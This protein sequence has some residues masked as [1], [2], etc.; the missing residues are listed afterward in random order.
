M[1]G[2]QQSHSSPVQGSPPPPPNTAESQRSRLLEN[3][4]VVV[5][6]R[7]SHRAPSIQS[8]SSSSPAETSAEN[9]NTTSEH[10]SAESSESES[11]DED[12]IQVE[13]SFNRETSLKIVHEARRPSTSSPVRP[14]EQ[15]LTDQ[16]LDESAI[17]VQPPV[18]KPA[19]IP[20]PTAAMA[21]TNRTII[22][23]PHDV[24]PHPSDFAGTAAEDPESWLNFLQRYCKCKRMTDEMFTENFGLY[25]K[26]MALQWYESLSDTD[27]T[28][29]ARLID[30]FKRRFYLSN[31]EKLRVMSDLF[32]RQQ[33]PEESVDEYF[34]QMQ[35]SARILG[36]VPDEQLKNAI[37]LG[38]KPELKKH[39]M[40]V[41]PT[42]LQDL[43]RAAKVAESAERAAGPSSIDISE[44][45]KR[46]ELTLMEGAARP[47]AVTPIG[48]LDKED[49]AKQ[50]SA[51][52]NQE[53][54]GRSQQRTALRD[55]SPYRSPQ[56]RSYGDRQP[57]VRF[58]ASA[59]RSGSYDDD[60]TG[61]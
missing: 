38:L 6:E 53:N 59:D 8:A 23:M 3:Q 42:S 1:L 31:I 17:Q 20:A 16:P 34:S 30:A 47:R 15:R 29:K 27:K 2:I 12:V 13:P 4:E 39:A 40:Q 61:Y 33:Q 24:H 21:V 54:E 58:D 19:P 56:S 5:E 45:L 43:L 14:G 9:P 41:S 57:Q 11:W 25:L 55:N 44:T 26:H 36:N 32:R 49:R 46:I 18:S 7:I 22:N 51:S 60:A 48:D 50:R 28:S 35:K 37:L 52:A 10:E